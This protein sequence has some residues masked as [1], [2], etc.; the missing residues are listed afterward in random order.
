MRVME[1]NSPTYS[2]TLLIGKG[3]CHECKFHTKWNI[4][5]SVDY[6]SDPAMSSMIDYLCKKYKVSNY[7][8]DTLCYLLFKEITKSYHMGDHIINSIDSKLTLYLTKYILKFY[9]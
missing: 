7:G 5:C 8:T 6:I 4:S 9:D 2:V 1:I 3:K